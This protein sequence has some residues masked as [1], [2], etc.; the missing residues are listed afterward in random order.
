MSDEYYVQDKR[1][2]V[3]NSMLWWKRGGRGYGCDLREAEVFSKE[4]AAKLIESSGHKYRAWPKEYIDSRVSHHID[5]QY[6]E[7]DEAFKP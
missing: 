4:G 3:G 7:T 6:C 5:F 2:I 1:Q